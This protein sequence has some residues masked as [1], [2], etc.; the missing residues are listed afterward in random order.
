MKRRTPP[1]PN[2]YCFG[3]RTAARMK[4]DVLGTY[5]KLQSEF[6]DSVSFVTGPYRLFLF[7]H[8]EQVRE[9]LVTHAKS[10]I[11]LPRVMKTL[12]QWNGNS[13]LISEGEQWVRQRRLVQPA[14]HPRR[15]E[16][17]GRTMVA[18]ARELVESWRGGDM[19]REGYVDVDIDQTM[20]SLTLS[21]ICQTMFDSRID[22]I[23]GEVAD[24]VSILSDVAFHEMQDPI[25]LP[26]WLPTAWNRRK[27]WA[28]NVLD[29]AVWSFVRQRRQ[30]GADHGDLLSMLLAAVDE[31]SGGQRLDDR[32]VRDEA[33]TLM[34]AGHDTTAAGLDWLWYNVAS[35]P[36]VARRCQAE[37]DA[38]VG[39][40]EPTAGDVEKL[41]YLVATIKESLR[42]YPP[43]IGVFLR[44]AT[45]D[46]VIGGYDVPKKKSLITL[47]SFV[48]QRDP[49][50]F[51]NPEQFDPDRFLPP[52][53]DEIPHG[54][55][56]PFGA[57]PR[58]CIGQSF[59]MTEMALIAATM[60]QSCTVMT[61]PGAS[62][63]SWDVKMA[64]RPKGK[65][66]L[67]WTARPGCQ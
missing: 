24:A 59:A 21:I 65:L 39:D 45:A 46:L 64:L 26:I 29:R 44:Q 33:M 23:S 61:I 51:P 47:S 42:L 9:V 52:R 28:M 25:R 13:I 17:Y 41:P 57:G 49:R 55:Y 37:V 19:R 43:A 3:F 5:T 60:F 56:F 10:L 16:N 14:F 22:D 48:T 12:A 11:R 18:A 34:L 2:D 58:V 62:D 63:P 66:L 67:R 20:T 27:R 6:G 54:A 31:E 53:A 1:G 40:R 35:N 32:Q 50:W 15:L 7:Y 38:I 30:D 4:S 8:P 36:E